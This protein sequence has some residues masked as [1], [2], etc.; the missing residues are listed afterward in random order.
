MKFSRFS[1]HIW[2]T[3]AKQPIL[4]LVSVAGTALAIFLIMILVM[5]NEVDVAPFPPETNRQRWLVQ[6][7]MSIGNTEW[8]STPELNTSNGPMSY[9]TIRRTF[10]EMSIPEAVTAFSRQNRSYL[11]VKGKNPLSASRIDTDAGFWKVMDFSFISGKG[12]EEADVDARSQ[13]AVISESVARRLF[14]ST[15]CV[16]RTLMLDHVPYRV[17]GVVRDVTNLS[18]FACAEIWVPLTSNDTDRQVWSDHMGMLSAIILARD[19]NDFPAIREEYDKVWSKFRDEI[20]D[21]GWEIY[22]RGRPLDQTTYINTPYVN[23]EPDM[24]SVRR[25]DLFIF[26]IL[27]LIPAINLS[28]MTQSRLHHRRQEIGVRRA[29][30]ATRADIIREIFTESLIVTVAAGI[31]G[32]LLS[33]VFIFL[34]GKTVLA[35]GN[36]VTGLT[37]GMVL[38]M[39]VFLKA[40]FFCF[41]LNLFSALAPAWQASRTNVVNALSARE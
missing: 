33:V 8:G 34:G 10:Y 15:D 12:Y 41:L 25:R 18:S 30:G 16:G 21:S 26:G 11:S 31:L 24:E 22:L 1:R 23:Q 37:L 20:K 29:F 9:N 7:G 36:D 19:K 40:L 27:L 2:K 17:C 38:N 28:S 4:S 14:N 39:S 3:L 13:V 35:D 6:T 32:L 5:I